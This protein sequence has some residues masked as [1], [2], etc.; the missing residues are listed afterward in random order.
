[1]KLLLDT[2]A[3]LWALAAPERLTRVEQEHIESPENDVV[4]SAVTALEIAIEQSLGKLDLPGPA[5]VW[6]PEQVA[7]AGFQWIPFDAEDGLAVR[8]LPWHHRDPFDRLLVAQALRS[9]RTIVTHDGVF[10]DYGV[11]V[12]GKRSTLRGSSSTTYVARRTGRPT[13]EAGSA[14]R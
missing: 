10:A 12:L 3:L 2:H 8:A 11:E 9:G 6:L 5:E 7:A 4:V 13:S 14:G 1:V